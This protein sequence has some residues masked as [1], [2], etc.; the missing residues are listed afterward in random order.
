LFGVARKEKIRES[1]QEWSFEIPLLEDEKVRFNA[2]LGVVDK[3]TQ[4]MGIFALFLFLNSLPGLIALIGV[5]SLPNLIILVLRLVGFLFILFTIRFAKRFYRIIVTDHRVLFQQERQGISGLWGRRI[6]MHTDLPLSML[7][8]F[9]V[10]H[11]SG[12]SVSGIVSSLILLI[13]GIFFYYTFTDPF[14]LLLGGLGFGLV[15]AI[16]Y[17]TT[18]EINFLTQTGE[19][20]RFGYHLP[21]IISWVSHRLEKYRLYNFLFPNILNEDKILGLLNSC[22]GIIP[23]LEEQ[24]Q[25]SQ[26]KIEYHNFLAPTEEEKAV[27]RK[28]G[29]QAFYRISLLMAVI[30]S[31]LCIP[32][33]FYYLLELDPNLFIPFIIL[34]LCGI[35]VVSLRKLVTVYRTLVVT[36]EKQQK[37]VLFIEEVIPR[38]IARIF[39]VLPESYIYEIGGKSIIGTKHNLITGDL[40]L[41]KL[42][43]SSTILVGMT[44]TIFG[45][46]ALIQDVGYQNLFL[47]FVGLGVILCVPGWIHGLFR[48]IPRYHLHLQGN[49][50]ALRIP[51]LPGIRQIEEVLHI[52]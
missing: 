43:T 6:F 31:L 28:F 44:L 23:T 22:R 45:I 33:T 41:K 51:F 10:S 29:P 37:R 34:S 3:K 42:L 16:T 38:K 50:F 17:R 21:G 9:S 39:G 13:T 7:Q 30:L 20:I 32:F 15:L 24:P 8:G 49:F 48:I 47:F 1:A 12:I 5:Y 4:I 35:L 27:W 40:G 2:R 46:K 14:Y 19:Q 36:E 52:E 11:F 18:S 25:K 26:H